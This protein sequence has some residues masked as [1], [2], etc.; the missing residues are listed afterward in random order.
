M[1]GQ[2]RQGV[3][4][5]QALGCRLQKLP[6]QILQ[7]KM[8][9]VSTSILSMPGWDFID[10]ATFFFSFLPHYALLFLHIVGVGSPIHIFSILVVVCSHV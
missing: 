6:T 9:L 5:F 2:S 4:S 8:L 3:V 1:Q 7:V 10:Y